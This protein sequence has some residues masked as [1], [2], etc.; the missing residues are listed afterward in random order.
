MKLYH[1][2]SLSSLLGIIQPNCVLEFWGSRH[3]CMNDPFDYTF[4]QNKLIDM[5]QSCGSMFSEGD[6]RR[7]PVITYPY[8]VSFSKRADDILMWR[9]YNAKVALILDSEYFDRSGNNSA[10]L[11]CKYTD[12]NPTNICKLN[13]ELNYQLKPCHNIYAYAGRGSS[14]IKYDGF[15]VEREV[16]LVTWEYY[17]DKGSPLILSD[18]IDKNPIASDNSFYRIGKNN[19]IIV[20]KKFRI[21]GNAL[22][23]II[24]NSYFGPEVQQMKDALTSLLQNNG[25]SLEVINNIKETQAY[26]CY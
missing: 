17:S 21:D 10:L 15:K 4:A 22:S 5:V 13:S 6:I 11:E 14:F 3:D 8:I 1:Y 16:R 9:L 12:N 18:C 24:L 19:R 2:T 7:F 25:F 23:G 26:P 20:Y